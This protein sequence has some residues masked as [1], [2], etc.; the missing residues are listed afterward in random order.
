MRPRAARN[1]SSRRLEL[2]AHV[3]QRGFQ[4]AQRRAASAV[5]AVSRIVRRGD[6]RARGADDS[7]PPATVRD[8]PR[9]RAPVR[10]CSSSRLL[11][12][13]DLLGQQRLHP[14]ADVAQR[15]FALDHAG[16]RILVTRQTQP[17]GAQPHAVARD[18]RLPGRQLATSAS[19]SAKR[20]GRE[21]RRQHRAQAT[22]RPAPSPA[23]RRHRPRR[24]WSNPR[25]VLTI[26]SWPP[27][28]L[29]S[30][31]ATPSRPSTHTASR[32]DPRARS[33]PR[34]SQPRS[35]RSCCAT[36]GLR[37][38]A[39]GPSAIASPCPTPCRARPA[40]RASVDTCV[41]KRLLPVGCAAHSSAC[42]CSRSRSRAPRTVPRA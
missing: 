11:G 9:V 21:D 27:S 1:S 39:T 12:L 15:L 38:P 40:A 23:A 7:L 36:R 10:A 8:G 42:V 14:L 24:P 30:R 13:L 16:V 19:A 37:D 2:G 29:P 31:S 18:H 26:A 3:G 22:P 20:F 6:R 5:R 4:L 25:S 35:T 32:Y 34:V 41:P 28:K 33:Q 17:I